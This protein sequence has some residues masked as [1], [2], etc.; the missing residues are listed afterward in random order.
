[1]NAAETLIAIAAG[2][3]QGWTVALPD[4]EVLL[5][6]GSTQRRCGARGLRDQQPL[7]TLTEP[8]FGQVLSELLPPLAQALV[9]QAI[10]TQ[11]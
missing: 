9:G 3:G 7:S 8:Q 6:E 4:Y 2:L 10:G 5:A 1:M 11:T